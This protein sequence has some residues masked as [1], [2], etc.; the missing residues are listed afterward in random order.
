MLAARLVTSFT[1]RSII[2]VVAIA[3]RRRGVVSAIVVRRGRRRRVIVRLLMLRAVGRAGDRCNSA[4]N[5]AA[6]DHVAEAVPVVMML[7]SPASRFGGRGGSERQ[8]RGTR[9]DDSEL[10]IHAGHVRLPCRS[11]A[12]AM[13]GM[14]D[15]YT[16]RFRLS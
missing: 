15:H 13:P 4:K 3:R 2:V 16:R 11:H 7:V 12:G 14:F 5:Q 9:R 10:R 8:R 1:R 6:D